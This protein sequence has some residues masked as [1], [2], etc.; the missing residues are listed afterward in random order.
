MLY[1]LADSFCKTFLLI[2]GILK[3]QIVLWE[4]ETKGPAKG[5]YGKAVMV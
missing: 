1:K 5:K 4:K 2:F 3:N